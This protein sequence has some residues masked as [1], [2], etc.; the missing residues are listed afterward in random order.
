MGARARARSRKEASAC[1]RTGVT[2]T[3]EHN[4]RDNE[5][6]LCPVIICNLDFIIARCAAAATAMVVATVVRRCRRWSVAVRLRRYRA[7][8]TAPDTA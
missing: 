2:A 4:A 5:R 6:E 3:M 1:H 8:F 7:R